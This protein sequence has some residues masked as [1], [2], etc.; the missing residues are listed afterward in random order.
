MTIRL[1]SP[2]KLRYAKQLT[3]L[4]LGEKTSRAKSDGQFS[5]GIIGLAIG[6]VMR[7]NRCLGCFWIRADTNK[8]KMCSLHLARL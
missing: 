8:R 6:V 3:S 1:L 2:L 5:R 7:F 4:S